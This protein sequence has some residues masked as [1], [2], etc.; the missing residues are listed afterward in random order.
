MLG[1]QHL[2]MNTQNGFVL[3]KVDYKRWEVSVV[4]RPNSGVAEIYD[5]VVDQLDPR[6]V[7]ISDFGGFVIG[8]LVGDKIVFNPRRE[9]VIDRLHCKKLA[10]NKLYGLH[11]MGR[12]NDSNWMWQY[13]KTDLNALTEEII[14]VHFAFD[15]DFRIISWK[16]RSYFWCVF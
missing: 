11:S 13:H 15:R 14:N 16:V 9:F 4:S 7:F 8:N 1:Q 10:D 6:K 5:V 2:L 12:N 3:L